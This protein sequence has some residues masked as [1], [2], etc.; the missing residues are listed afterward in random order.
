[1]VRQWHYRPHSV[2]WAVQWR[3]NPVGATHQVVTI[4][5]WRRFRA[6]GGPSSAGTANCWLSFLT[7]NAPCGVGEG[8]NTAYGT[9]NTDNWTSTTSWASPA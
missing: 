4:A 5:T 3:A 9:C 1:M 7:N 2:T 8:G 6:D